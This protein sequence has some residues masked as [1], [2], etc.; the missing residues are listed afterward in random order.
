MFEYESDETPLDDGTSG[1]KLTDVRKVVIF[2][3]CVQT[4]RGGRRRGLDIPAS[5][6]KIVE[7]C[8]HNS[9]RRA[10][11]KSWKKSSTSPNYTLM[12]ATGDR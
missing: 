5:M 3:D 1:E 2:G 12:S 7:F 11:A 10:S 4:A 6:A 8:A 9:C